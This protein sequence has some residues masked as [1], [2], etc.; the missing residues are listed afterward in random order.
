MIAAVTRRAFTFVLALA[1]LASCTE[2]GQPAKS[3]PVNDV[4]GAPKL[5]RDAGAVLLQVSAYDYGLAGALA[6][7]Q[8]RTVAAARY[9]AVMRGTTQTIAA[10]NATVLAGTLDR[11]GPIRE[12]LVPL[13]DG[14]SDL[15]RDGVAYADGADP[16]A[17]ARVVS[18]VTAGW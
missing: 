11:T 5:A 3:A 18:D 7:E 16:A 1:F 10:F 14:L 6:G 13:A 4:E 15:A 2:S 17:F 12:K 8:T 9:G